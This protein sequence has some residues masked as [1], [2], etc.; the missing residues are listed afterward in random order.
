[1]VLVSFD[2]QWSCSFVVVVW[3]LLF[4]VAVAGSCSSIV[5]LRAEV[6]ELTM[7]GCLDCYCW[8]LLLFCLLVFID[9]DDFW[10]A[11]LGLAS[12]LFDLCSLGCT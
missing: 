12:T 6:C 9:D 1:M 5:L 11:T 4:L 8:S 3:P 7:G 10:Y 2:A